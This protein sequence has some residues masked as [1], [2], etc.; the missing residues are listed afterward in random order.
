L[1]NY[2]EILSE[3]LQ[4]DKENLHLMAIHTMIDNFSDRES[5]WKVREGAI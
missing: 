5:P 1:R 3:C 4:V 2:Y